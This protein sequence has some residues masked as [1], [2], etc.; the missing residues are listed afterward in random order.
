MEHDRL[1][2][3]KTLKVAGFL[4]EFEKDEVKKRVDIVS[5]FSS[6]G[7]K[8]T[9]KGKSYTGLCP[10]HDDN[11][12]SLSVDREKGL[13]N[14]FGCGESGDVFSLVE[15]MKGFSFREA[16]EYLKSWSGQTQAAL[17]TAKPA[18]KKKT[19]TPDPH[20]PQPAASKAISPTSSEIPLRTVAE[21]Y[22]KKLYSNREA[23]GYLEKRGLSSG[24]LLGRFGVGFAD[25]SLVSKISNGQQGKLKGL[26]ILRESG[27]EHFYGCITVPLHD[28]SGSITGFYGRKINDNGK[29]KHLYLKGPHRGIF[30][31][32]ASAVYDEIILT[33]SI[34]DSLS[35]LSLGI[36]NVQ[37][38]YGTNGLTDEHLAVLK[39][40]RVKTVTLALDNDDAGRKASES[41][42]ERLLAEGFVVKLITPPAGKD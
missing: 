13:Y 12:P 37:S 11:N 30:N 7:I 4:D 22:H 9:R 38:L 39:A 19:A 26:G 25:G 42:K 14:C 6:F 41:L 35:L 24:E 18:G 31:C 5:L 33:E 27:K 8:L 29:L 36:Q 32:K 40:D 3:K 15:K 16:L 17:S 1:K 23:K 28:S 34:L 21:Y 20:E 2:G 10:W